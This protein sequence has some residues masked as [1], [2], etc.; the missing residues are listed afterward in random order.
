MDGTV[1]DKGTDGTHLKPGSLISTRA[2]N[3]RTVAHPSEA[4][5]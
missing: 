4:E 5:R 3:R 1:F 2:P